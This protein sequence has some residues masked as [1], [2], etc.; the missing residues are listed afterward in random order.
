MRNRDVTEKQTAKPLSRRWGQGQ[1]FARPPVPAAGP[2]LMVLLRQL[3][4]CGIDAYAPP[5]LAEG[6]DP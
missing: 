3:A 1:A 6:S 2:D 4:I 5:L